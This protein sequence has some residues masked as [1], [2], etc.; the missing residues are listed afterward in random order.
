MAEPTSSATSILPESF[1]ECV[2]LYFECETPEERDGF[3]QLF[4]ERQGNEVIA[5]LQAM[6]AEDED[7]FVRIAAARALALRGDAAGQR[8]LSQYLTVSADDA[9]LA[10]AVAATVAYKQGEAADELAA[11]FLDEERSHGERRLAQDGLL[12]ASFERAA[13]VFAR[14]LESQAPLDSDLVEGMMPALLEA[15]PALRSQ[16]ARALGRRAQA[17]REE[18]QRLLNSLAGVTAGDAYERAL[19]GVDEARDQF[20]TLQ[21]CQQQLL[22]E[23]V[24]A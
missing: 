10:A 3:V 14:L 22:V 7:V 23:S 6:M 12:Q 2:E 16:A 1:D 24:A 15:A 17:H 9:V 8:L 5:F 13:E 20:E 11:L 4:S 19:D 21:A 18:Q